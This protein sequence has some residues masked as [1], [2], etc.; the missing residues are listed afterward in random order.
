MAKNRLFQRKSGFWLKL[1]TFFAI[2][3]EKVYFFLSA[4]KK[5]GIPARR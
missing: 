5:S 1:L 4:E 3:V 2:S